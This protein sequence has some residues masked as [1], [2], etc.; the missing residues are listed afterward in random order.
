[1]PSQILL[2]ALYVA[3]ICTIIHAI[4]IILFRLRN[5]GEMSS[6]DYMT[7]TV[8]FGKKKIFFI[9]SQREAGREKIYCRAIVGGGVYDTG[10]ARLPAAIEREAKSNPTTGDRTA[11]R[12]CSGSG[13]CISC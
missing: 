8:V 4:T 6:Y 10:R 7:S 3:T 5:T 1:T 13:S 2:F 11:R 12:L 9:V